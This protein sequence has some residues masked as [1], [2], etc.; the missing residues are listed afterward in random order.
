MA[1]SRLVITVLSLCIINAY[2]FTP[3]TYYMD[4]ECGY[5]LTTTKDTRLKLTYYP[6]RSLHLNMNC[7]TSF[8]TT[9]LGDRL[10]VRLRSIDTVSTPNCQKNA[11]QIFDSDRQTLLNAP[12][13]DCGT[14]LRTRTYK[15]S[16]SSVT[17]KF[18][19]DASFQ[20]GQFDIL[21]T[22]FNKAFN[23]SCSARRFTCDNDLCISN[24]L[25][26]NGYNDCGDDSDEIYECR[27]SGGAIAGIAVGVI[28]FLVIC[29]FLSIVGRARRR[30]YQRLCEAKPYRA[31][32]TT[33]TTYPTNVQN[34]YQQ[35][36][37][38]TY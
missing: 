30:R 11:L 21:V 34:R 5:S 35:P 29:T 25:T 31:V 37:Y 10:Q 36:S 14:V 13:G 3:M 9:V 15:S 18:Q 6:S 1:S 8:R 17:L 12:F 20:Y 23:H 7:T 26:C 32:Q 16:G 33:T 24:T 28:V 22:S 38:Q 19:T 2:G 4:E 27:L